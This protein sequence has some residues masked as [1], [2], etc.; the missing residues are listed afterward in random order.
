[1]KYTMMTDND[2]Y[3]RQEI[4]QSDDTDDNKENNYASSLL[5]SDKRLNRLNMM[6]RMKKSLKTDNNPYIS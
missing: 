5:R 1:M 3:S 2:P 6:T 4:L